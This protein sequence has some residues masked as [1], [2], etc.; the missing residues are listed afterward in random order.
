MFYKTTPCGEV[1]GPT[2]NDVRDVIANLIVPI[3]ASENYIYHA[4]A[5]LGLN[6][7]RTLAQWPGMALN[8]NLTGSHPNDHPNLCT[9]RHVWKD[10]KLP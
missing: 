7:C 8:Y 5:R 4:T 10:Y 3:V 1:V 9:R 6:S 2:V